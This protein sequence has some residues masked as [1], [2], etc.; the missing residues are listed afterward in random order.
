MIRLNGNKEVQLKCRGTPQAKYF[1]L[2][3]QT[4]MS[5]PDQI[6]YKKNLK[7]HAKKVDY[8]NYHYQISMWWLQCLPVNMSRMVIMKQ[9][10]STQTK[11]ET[12]MDSHMRWLTITIWHPWKRTLRKR[13]LWQP[14]SMKN[15]QLKHSKLPYLK[16]QDLSSQR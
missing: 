10:P 14:S 12:S 15:F 4:A 2:Q 9:Y 5:Q 13:G 8:I 1:Q 3:L 16:E 7:M 11:E 6:A